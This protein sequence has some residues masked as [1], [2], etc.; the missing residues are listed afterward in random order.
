MSKRPKL[1]A[2]DL[3]GTIVRHDGTISQRT[4]D[5]F[6]SAHKLGIEIFF[7]TGR[8]PRWMHEIRDTFSFG[9]AICGNGAML[10]NLRE[11]KVTE[12]WMISSEQQ[13][14]VAQIMRKSIPPISFAIES[15]DYYHR[16][17]IY[18][19]R[20]DVGLDNVGVD[21]IED[22]VRGPAFK[23]LARCSDGEFTSDQMLE[24]ALRE[25]DGIVTVTHSNARESLLEISALGVSKGATLAKV[26]ARLS[27]DARDCV[28]F[29]DNPNDFSMLSWCGR[30]YAMADGHPDGVTF[31][32]SVAGPHKEDGVAIVIEELLQLPA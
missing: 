15:H 1:I 6:T 4:V 18:V 25:L 14:E 13:I 10:Y 11:S 9:E 23:M 30:S 24:I 20:W 21:R 3:D 12:E 29:G 7:V 32:T 28:S 16:E 17:K 31:A 27:I 8:P 2:T 19:P 5:A 22:A 26:A